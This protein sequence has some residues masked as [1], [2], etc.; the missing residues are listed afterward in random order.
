MRGR[1]SEIHWHW[2][3]E[4][5]KV[6]SFRVFFLLPLIFSC[7]SHRGHELPV[8]THFPEIPGKIGSV[9]FEI[10]SPDMVENPEEMETLRSQVREHL[11]ATNLFERVLD[12]GT[13]SECHIRI[14]LAT[15]EKSVG[16]FFS[17][18]TFT[19]I[20]MTASAD[21]VYR[22]DIFRNAKR[23]TSFSG[24]TRYHSRFGILLFPKLF[25]DAPGRAKTRM[26]GRM[27]AINNALLQMVE[28]G[29]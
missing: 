29:P 9:S 6:R 14:Y 5:L 21:E 13:S 7:A 11:L 20:P 22:I 18:L 26:L 28:T 1:I 27:N 4:N 3:V 2:D 23:T 24:N 8:I 10:Q 17:I 25:S 19:I 16:I 12:Q 15:A